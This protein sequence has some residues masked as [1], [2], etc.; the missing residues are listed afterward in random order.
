[1]AAAVCQLQKLLRFTISPGRGGRIS[2]IVFFPG[3]CYNKMQ[4]FFFPLRPRMR[5]VKPADLSGRTAPGASTVRRREKT[6]AIN[7]QTRRDCLL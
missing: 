2:G 7:H 4:C 6:P 3:F 1:M 5:K